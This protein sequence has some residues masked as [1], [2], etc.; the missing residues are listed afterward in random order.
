MPALD[1][2]EVHA[3]KET[4]WGTGVPGT[5]KLMGVESFDFAPG[6]KAEVNSDL[7]GSLGPG[8]IAY[9]TEQRGEATMKQ[10]LLYEDA[11][12]WFDAMFGI[13]TP[14]GAAPTVSRSWTAPGPAP[15]NPRFQSIAYGRGNDAYRLLGAVPT[16]LEISGETKKPLMSTIGLIG[17][18][19]AA[20]T[21]MATLTD[22]VVTPVM[23]HHAEVF[24]DTWSGTIGTTPLPISA[25]GFKLV[26]DN[27]RTLR[28]F[29]G[30]LLPAAFEDQR[31]QSKNNTLSLMAD[32]NATM[33][34]Y[35]TSIV[36]GTLTQLQVRLRFT[37][38]ANVWE[39]DFAGT[40][41]EAPKL[42]DDKDGVATISIKLA[43]THNTGL[44]SWL[45]T[46]LVNGVAVLA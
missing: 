24:I 39:L 7:R 22:R 19:V 2:F 3:G 32:F 21:S 12:Y 30:S 11:A 10:K 34:P 31:Y 37:S 4:T 27:G 42:W 8:Q 6:T 1:L 40:A 18:E 36:S 33:K 35:V 41:T 46:R 43:A 13:A 20:L 16:K 9:V 38:G 29:L 17:K 5:V 28:D 14:S 23:P 26:L 45:K 15:T 25:F 44:G